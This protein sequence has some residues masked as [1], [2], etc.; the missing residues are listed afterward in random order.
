MATLKK[1]N[2]NG[3]RVTLEQ[4][5]AE[6]LREI[7]QKHDGTFKGG[8]GAYFIITPGDNECQFRNLA[9]QQEWAKPTTLIGYGGVVENVFR[10]PPETGN[11]IFSGP[12]LC[13]LVVDENHR[14]KGFGSLL[15]QLRLDWLKQQGYHEAFFPYECEKDID[16]NDPPAILRVFKELQKKGK[17]KIEKIY[18]KPEGSKQAYRVSGF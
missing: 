13:D 12:E 5:D 18:Q 8:W 4:I 14:R 11:V 15:V 3:M 1:I 17:L 7:A 9:I 2:H 6:E 16:N 10:D